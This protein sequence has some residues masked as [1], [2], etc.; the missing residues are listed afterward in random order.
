MTNDERNQ[1]NKLM[2]RICRI[3]VMPAIGG[4]GLMLSVLT[5]GRS[6][7]RPGAIATM[8]NPY[9]GN[10]EQAQV[11]RMTLGITAMAKGDTWRAMYEYEEALDTIADSFGEAVCGCAEKFAVKALLGIE[12]MARAIGGILVR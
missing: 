11:V 6:G 3:G 5:I 1:I 9:G 7:G 10:F 12:S 8:W 2:A 4:D